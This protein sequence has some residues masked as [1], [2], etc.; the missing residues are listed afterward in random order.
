CR[1]ELQ[2]AQQIFMKYNLPT[3]NTA[4]KS[5]EELAAQISQ[6]IGLYRKSSTL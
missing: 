4:D 5:I 2:Q 3:I 1:Q 6:E